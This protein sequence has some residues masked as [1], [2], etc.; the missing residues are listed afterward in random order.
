MKKIWVL[1]VLSLGIP[2][3]AT[4]YTVNAGASAATI[5]QIVNT[6]SSGPGNTVMFSAGSYGLSSTVNLPCSNGTVYTGPNVGVVTLT[7]RPVA[8]LT[9]IVTTNYALEVN[10]NGTSFTG[11]QG[12]TI[13]YL[14]FS[15]TQGGIY[16]AHP[17]SGIVIQY[18][19]FT[20]NNPPVGGGQSRQAIYLDG[21]QNLGPDPSTGESY[22]TIVWN[23]FY[24]NCRLINAEGGG[25]GNVDS[26]GYCAATLVMAYNNHLVWSNN[27]VNL[28]EEGLKLVEESNALQQTSW[29]A[30]VE[31]NNLRGN[32]RIMI[33]SQQD[34]NGVGVYSHNAFYQPNNPNNGTFELS[35]PEWTPSPS[36]THVA[37]D[38][39]YIGNVPI[40]GETGTGAHYGIGLELG[41]AGSI[42]TNS[43]YQGGNGPETCGAGQFCTGWG[44]MVG[45]SFTSATISGN[46][47]SGTDVWNGSAS[48]LT[49]AVNYEGSATKSNA[50][51]V[52]SS[53]TVVQT[54]TTNP[55][56]PPSSLQPM[57]PEVPR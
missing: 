55:I 15:G 13:Q 34:T 56:A 20:L 51:L 41:G 47:F 28:V 24:D 43:L 4:T 52:L 40:T 11:G 1:A 27:T 29:N 19:Y 14:R 12:C 39:V 50:G 6:A 2:A 7:N 42:A 48:D 16:I 30:D 17:A 9:N 49:K 53:N 25:N 33:E 31:N 44:I 35:L 46:Y 10:S 37:D 21:Y 8:V 57:V 26:G 5:Q 54:S 32:S 45:G 36:P 38:N 3:Q 18:N 22:I 23:V